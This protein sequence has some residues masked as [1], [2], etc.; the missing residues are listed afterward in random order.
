MQNTKPFKHSKQHFP[1]QFPTK[2][3]LHKSTKQQ[4]E[5]PPQSTLETST[6]NRGFFISF[7]T[8]FSFSFSN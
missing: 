8:F 5:K 4:A 2:L 1:P 7:P 6:E 3:K